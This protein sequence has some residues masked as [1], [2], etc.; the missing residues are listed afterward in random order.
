MRMVNEVQNQLM[1]MCYLSL[2]NHLIFLIH[3]K[4]M[5]VHYSHN[6]MIVVWQIQCFSSLKMPP[7]TCL[8]SVYQKELNFR[9]TDVRYTYICLFLPAF[10]YGQSIYMGGVNLTVTQYILDFLNTENFNNLVDQC[11]VVR[12]NTCIQMSNCILRITI[13]EQFNNNFIT[14]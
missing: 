4:S 11:N 9:C 8:L 14:I 5:H 13:H 3:Q 10:Q 7:Y 6:V 12:R 1:N 2:H